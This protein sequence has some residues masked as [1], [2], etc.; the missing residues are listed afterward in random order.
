MGPWAVRNATGR[1]VTVRFRLARNDGIVLVILTPNK[2]LPHKKSPCWPAYQL[3]SGIGSLPIHPEAEDLGACHHQAA[4]LFH[5]VDPAE[6]L[7]HVAGPEVEVTVCPVQI[8]LQLLCAEVGE[9]LVE[10]GLLMEVLEIEASAVPDLGMLLRDL[11]EHLRSRVGRADAEGDGARPEAL[12]EADA[13]LNRLP[14]VSGHAQHHVGVG[15]DAHLTTEL[16]G[17]PGLLQRGALADIVEYALH[18]GFDTEL[19][20]MAAC[21]LHLLQHLPRHGVHA[22]VAYPGDVDFF[23]AQHRV[24]LAVPLPVHREGLVPE[25]HFAEA[26]LLEIAH[27][28]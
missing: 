5:A 8:R 10:E 4:Q 3:Q 28:F 2:P 15:V 23:L 16:E 19:D 9:V 26:A 22:G 24:E 18:P 7:Q 6:A 1:L 27:L 17:V 14:G 25:P 11:E 12:D 20:E 21:A 13:L